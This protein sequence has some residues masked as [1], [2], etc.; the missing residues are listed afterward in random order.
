MHARS[1]MIKQ[2]HRQSATATTTKSAFQCIAW[3]A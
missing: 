3:L 1:T 2:C